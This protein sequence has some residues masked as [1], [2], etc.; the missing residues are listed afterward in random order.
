M[1]FAWAGLCRSRLY[2]H[3]WS[4]IEWALSNTEE[5]VCSFAHTIENGLRK[6]L[7]IKSTRKRISNNNSY[8][9]MTFSVVKHSIKAIGIRFLALLRYLTSKVEFLWILFLIGFVSSVVLKSDTKY[10]WDLNKVT[11][12]QRHYAG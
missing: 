10:I 7:F 4:T 5:K 8:F 11:Q 6:Y 3:N 2:I 1:N 9:F 12:S